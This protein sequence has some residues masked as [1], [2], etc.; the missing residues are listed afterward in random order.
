[1]SLV[2]DDSVLSSAAKSFSNQ[3]EVIQ[4][5]INDYH[6]IMTNIRQLSIMQGETAEAI[7]AFDSSLYGQINTQC[8]TLSSYLMK[9]VDEFNRQVDIADKDLYD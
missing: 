4:C 5:M 6:R 1:M 3:L 8:K 7:T 9:Q 2:Y